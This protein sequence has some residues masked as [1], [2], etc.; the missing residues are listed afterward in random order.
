MESIKDEFERVWET[1]WFGGCGR[2]TTVNGGPFGGRPWMMVVI[3]VGFLWCCGGG[4]WMVENESERALEGSNILFLLL[5][6]FWEK[7]RWRF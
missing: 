6:W 1:N 4:C 5:V 2:A 7:K 3:V